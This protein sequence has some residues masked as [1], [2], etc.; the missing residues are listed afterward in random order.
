MDIGCQDW[1]TKIKKKYPESLG[2]L[3]KV[4][5]IGSLNINGTARDYFKADE[6]VGIDMI[7]GKD[8]DLVVNAHDIHIYWQFQVFD[9][10]VCMNTLE[11]DNKFWLTLEQINKVLKKG[12]LLIY[13]QPTI[14]FPIHDHPGDYWR[15]TKQALQEVIFEGFEVLDIE[16]VYSKKIDDPTHRKGW[17]GINPILCGLGKKL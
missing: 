16:E 13:A 8:V 4:L 9:T 3:G 5:E 7:A 6:W 12:G 10:I 11:H 15:L 1:M 2:N 17:R 14:N